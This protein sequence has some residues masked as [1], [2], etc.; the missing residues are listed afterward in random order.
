VTDYHLVKRN[1]K[2][3]QWVR[4]PNWKKLAEG[5]GISMIFCNHLGGTD[6]DKW[7]IQY[8]TAGGMDE[9]G[10]VASV[11]ADGTD[12]YF[13]FLSSSGHFLTNKIAC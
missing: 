10:V 1:S 9:S 11:E 5:N 6:Q 2:T 7:M 13:V 3:A 4:S 8:D 12:M